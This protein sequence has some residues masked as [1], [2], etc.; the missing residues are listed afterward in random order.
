MSNSR[1]PAR[2]RADGGD[3]A[4]THTQRQPL[5]GIQPHCITRSSLL[6]LL[7]SFPVSLHPAVAVVQILHCTALSHSTRK[8]SILTRAPSHCSEKRQRD[9]HTPRPTHTE[10]VEWLRW[11]ISFPPA[12]TSVSPGR[13]SILHHSPTEACP[14]HRSIK[15]RNI[16][17]QSR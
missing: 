7:P 13:P 10:I 15:H 5:P 6:L 2:C 8:H 14:G 1:R 17:P 4:A 16:F 12:Q 11:S 9:Q 3:I